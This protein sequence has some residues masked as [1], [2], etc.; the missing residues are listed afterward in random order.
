M[1]LY[2]TD[3][4]VQGRPSQGAVG[5]LENVTALPDDHAEQ[6]IG[7]RY[8]PIGW[9]RTRTGQSVSPVNSAISA[10]PAVTPER[11]TDDSAIRQ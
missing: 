9:Q 4:A 1:E 5:C 8:I 6:I 10:A 3:P 2:S 11:D 7:E